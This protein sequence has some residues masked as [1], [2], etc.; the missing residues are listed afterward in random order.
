MRNTAISINQNIKEAFKEFDKDSVEVKNR[1]RADSQT[2]NMNLSPSLP[3]TFPNEKVT[4]DRFKHLKSF[5]ASSKLD[6]NSNPIIDYSIS[7]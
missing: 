4:S 6:N 2:S 1:K 3:T 5:K 7:T